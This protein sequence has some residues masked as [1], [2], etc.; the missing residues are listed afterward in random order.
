M[1]FTYTIQTTLGK[2][3]NVVGDKFWNVISNSSNIT[4]RSVQHRYVA[5][6]R[7]SFNL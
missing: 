2:I 5:V 1:P 3:I 4:A 7:F 6:D